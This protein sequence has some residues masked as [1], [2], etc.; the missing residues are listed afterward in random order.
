M[1]WVEAEVRV[2]LSRAIADT[3]FPFMPVLAGVRRT[4]PSPPALIEHFARPAL[5]MTILVGRA[6]THFRWDWRVAR[7]TILS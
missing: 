7:W 3:D 5:M 1:T 6:E 4:R 2:A